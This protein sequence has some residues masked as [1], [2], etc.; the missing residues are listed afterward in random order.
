[1][2]WDKGTLKVFFTLSIAK[3]TPVGLNKDT[4][5]NDI[6]LESSMK[7]WIKYIRLNIVTAKLPKTPAVYQENKEKY[8]IFI[9]L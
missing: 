4:S 6:E 5:Q 3:A 1:M 9:I 2:L 8:K 7:T